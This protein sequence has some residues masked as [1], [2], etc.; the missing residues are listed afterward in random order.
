MM[1]KEA[2]FV[3]DLKGLG[4]EMKELL[5]CLTDARYAAKITSAA[6]SVT[7]IMK[8]V[9]EAAQYINDF[10]NKGAF[11]KNLFFCSPS[12][13]SNALPSSERFTAAQFSKS[14]DGYKSKFVA[15]R[16]SFR[17]AMIVQI[18]VNVDELRESGSMI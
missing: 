1:K 16:E 12:D 5:T 14:L 7:E 2:E 6:N 8:T 11:S 3:S 15:L 10:M 4:N 17:D 13:L 18:A 9:L